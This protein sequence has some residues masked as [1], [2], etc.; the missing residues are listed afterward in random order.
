MDGTETDGSMNE[1]ETEEP[2]DAD[3]PGLG[4]VAALAALLSVALFVRRR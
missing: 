4:V 1:T 2:T 3:G